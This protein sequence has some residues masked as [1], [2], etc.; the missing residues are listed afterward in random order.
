MYQVLYSFKSHSDGIHPA[1]PLIKVNGTLYGTTT[2]GG[3][4]GAGTVYDITTTG[5]EKVLHSFGHG[6]DGA[7]PS[8]GLI[9]VN[10]T[11][12]GTTGSGGSFRPA[13]C[14]GA[15]GGCG[16]VYRISTTGAEKVL[17]S[18]RLGADGWYPGGGLIG[19]NGTL[20]G[21]TPYGG[22]G[23]G[24]T[25][26][27]TVFRITTTGSE[28]AIY[29]FKGGSDGADLPVSKLLHINDTLYG[30]T[31]LGGSRGCYYHNGCGTVFSITTAGKE[32]WLY[33]FTG[34][35]D[36]SYPDAGLVNVN[37][38]LYGT[39]SSGGGS[40]YYGTAYSI[41]TD[42]SEKIVYRF[43][44]RHS[45]RG[46]DPET[47][48]VDVNGTLYGTTIQ[49]G[50]F[51]AG[52][53]FSISTTGEVKVLHDFRGAPSDGLYP[54]GS[55]IYAHGTLYGTTYYGGGGGKGTCCGTVFALAL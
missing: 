15:S 23:C 26:C 35:S 18:F 45:A 20:Y 41:N 30:T 31:N 28:N 51:N 44:E 32:N 40:G 36:G 27:G 55:L 49:G 53:I 46:I 29:R 34:G 33:S 25:G 50:A 5:R 12:Y 24:S 39:T 4:A 19:V 54:L 1:D 10:G 43:S 38:M 8:G 21:T 22:S 7:G 14:G 52:T 48:L 3:S 47:G 6:S 11:L 17:H 42:G 13:G 37:G 2:R 9:D 16:T